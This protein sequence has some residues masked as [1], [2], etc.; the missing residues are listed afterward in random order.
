M[1]RAFPLPSLLYTS[2]STSY[3]P[4]TVLSILFALVRGVRS[5]FSGRFYVFPPPRSS[6][7][8]FPFFFPFWIPANRPLR[9]D[10]VWGRLPTANRLN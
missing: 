1:T 5:L 4:P 3:L 2:S 7:L 10:E 8:P 9:T 6:S